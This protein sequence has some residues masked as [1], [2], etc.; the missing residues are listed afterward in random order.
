[1]NVASQENSCGRQWA[2]S[3]RG[4]S[5]RPVSAPVMRVSIYSL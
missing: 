1:M 3:E 5:G 4:E 2:P